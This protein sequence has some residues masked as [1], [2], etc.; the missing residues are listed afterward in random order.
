MNGEPMQ[1]KPIFLSP[2]IAGISE[3]LIEFDQWVVW[4]WANRNGQMTKVP[5]NPKKAGFASSTKPDTWGSFETAVEAYTHGAYDGIGFVVTKESQIIG[6]DLDHC[7]NPATGQVEAWAEE[8]V[9]TFGTYTE[10]S[11]SATGIRMFGF[12]TL[13]PHGRHKDNIEMYDCKRFL[14]V[15]GHVMMNLREIR[16]CQEEI[17]A[18]HKEV[19]GEPKVVDIKQAK[20]S[21]THLE[22]EK[23]I[24]KA[25]SAKNGDRFSQLYA[26]KWEGDYNSQ[27]EADL[28]FCGLLAFWC[29]CAREQISRIFQASGLY[30]DKWDRQ[31]YRES[32][33]DKAISERGDTYKGKSHDQT[34]KDEGTLSQKD[35]D[36]PKGVEQKIFDFP[37]Q[38]LTGAAGNFAGVYNELIESCPQFLYMAYLSC[39][40]NV[41]CPKLS[42]K[43]TLKTPPRL[44]VVLV[45]ESAD[46]RK[47]T[48]IDAVV[49]FFWSVLGNDFHYSEGVGSAEGL[50]RILKKADEQYSDRA[51]GTLL[52]H[53]EFKAFVSK[54]NID[55]S[56]LLPCVNTLFEKTRYENSTKKHEIIIENAHLSMLAAS[57]I[58][59]YEKIY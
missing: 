24:Q 50:H 38:V 20:E 4:K 59:T 43:T 12:G 42:V 29:N 23:L 8:I 35:A 1:D 58:E 39:L 3:A 47:S 34:L 30:R 22:D 46:D 55:N 26:G 56:V 31:D 44:Y 16:P 5:Y 41:L 15:T 25:T 14:T 19:F 32:T 9:K 6:I 18:L 36:D 11:P 27:S 49:D 54:C 33:I 53:D 48:A 2:A 40:G 17:N 10:L 52:V 28:A 37:E 21:K 45:G 13:P 57:T 7:I 51:T